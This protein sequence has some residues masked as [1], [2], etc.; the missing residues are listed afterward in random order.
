LSG[1]DGASPITGLCESD[2]RDALR[3]E[4]LK[5][6]TLKKAIADARRHLSQLN[7]GMAN[8]VLS[9]VEFL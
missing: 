8:E 2:T 3:V 9:R 5:T 6:E 1:A 7:F 4:R